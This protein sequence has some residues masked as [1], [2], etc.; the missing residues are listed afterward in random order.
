MILLGFL[1]GFSWVGDGGKGREGEKAREIS[2][3]AGGFFYG[4]LMDPPLM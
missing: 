4:F 3:F 1:G 2:L